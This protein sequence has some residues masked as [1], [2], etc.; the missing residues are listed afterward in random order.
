MSLSVKFDT[1]YA[2]D[3]RTVYIIKVTGADGETTWTLQKRYSELRNLHEQLRVRHGDALP[4]FPGKRIFG[5]MDPAFVSARQAG[6][7]QYID[8]VLRIEREIRTT[9]LLQF[10]GGPEVQGERNQARQYQQILDNMQSRLLNLALPPSPLDEAEMTQRL[11]K[12]GQAMKL[13]VLSQP[14][15]PIHLRAPGFDTEP[16]PLCG[17]NAERFEA[18]KAAPGSGGD[19]AVLKDLMDKLH[20]V[21][22]PDQQIADADK[23]IVQFPQIERQVPQ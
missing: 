13:H 7:Q 16:P 11:K 20:E 17:T 9:A 8:G 10:L 23:I 6:L 5:S 21:L 15:D 14:V 19:A 2:Q 1:N 3:G 22:R 4:P 18:L 12:Y